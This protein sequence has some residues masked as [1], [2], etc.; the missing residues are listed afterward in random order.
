MKYA[1]YSVLNTIKYYVHPFLGAV[2]NTVEV[3]VGLSLIV[4]VIL[5]TLNYLW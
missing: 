1:K 3:I 5:F 2:R 4:F